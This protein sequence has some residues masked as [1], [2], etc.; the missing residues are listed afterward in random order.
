[1]RPTVDELRGLF[2]LREG[3][4]FWRT[5]V[6]NKSNN[7]AGKK[8]GCMD[9]YGYLTVGINYRIYKVHRVIFAIANGRWP[10][11]PV[12]HIN[13]NKADNRPENLRECTIY[14]NNCH[15]PANRNNTS[16]FKG[17]VRSQGKWHVKIRVC[18]KRINL[19]AYHDL[20]LAAFVYQCAAEKY[21]G[22]FAHS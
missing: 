16:G 17:V 22:A 5:D 12:D 14:Q 20:E 4:L 1:M 11:G 15:R 21:H 13:L 2:E 9:C 7:F 3:G 6:A 8:A 19:G 10:A 18:G